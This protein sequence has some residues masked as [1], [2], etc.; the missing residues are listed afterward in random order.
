M[1]EAVAVLR[2]RLSEEGQLEVFHGAF[3]WIASFQWS[4]TTTKKAIE[5][6]ESQLGIAL[7][8]DYREFLTSVSNGAI[9]YYGVHGQWGYM[10][11]SVEKLY[12]KNNLW[13][14]SIFLKWR[15]TFLVFAELFGEANAMV[16]DLDLPSN[17]RTGYAV[18]E[19]DAYDPEENWPIASHCFH[20]WL[21][22][23]ITAQ[24]DKYWL[25]K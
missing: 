20:E 23:L 6:A 8:D 24:G 17:D 2:N 1:F 4:T 5:E 14:D 10:I 13:K 3:S 22:H 16:F 18:L 12:E 25:W 21:D 15:P 7:P 9:L 19:G 11:Y